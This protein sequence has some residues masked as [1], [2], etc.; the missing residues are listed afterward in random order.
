[1]NIAKSVVYANKMWQCCCMVIIIAILLFALLMRHNVSAVKLNGAGP[2]GIG[3]VNDSCK[4]DGYISVFYWVEAIDNTNDV[5]VC[6]KCGY[7]K[8]ESPWFVRMIGHETYGPRILTTPEFF[9]RVIADRMMTHCT[10]IRRLCVWAFGDCGIQTQIIDEV[11]GEILMHAIGIAGVAECVARCV[12][13]SCLYNPEKPNDTLC[14][15]NIYFGSD[16]E[17]NK[18]PKSLCTGIWPSPGPAGKGEFCVVRMAKQNIPVIINQLDAGINTLKMLFQGNAR[19]DK[20]SK[21]KDWMNDSIV[22]A[23]MADKLRKK[24]DGITAT[25][26]NESCIQCREGCSSLPR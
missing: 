13:L 5:N 21:T 4:C 16:T 11:Y 3:W 6:I 9:H 19:D 12:M 26:N 20:F 1:M 18:Y 22:T 25:F 10:G 7:A 8:P 24:L 17:Y 2:G 14:P 15:M 23:R